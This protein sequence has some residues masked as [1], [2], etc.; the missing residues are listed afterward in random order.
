MQADI[1]PTDIVGWDIGGAHLKAS[2]LS[3]EGQVMAVYQEPCPLWQGLEKLEYALTNILARVPH[4]L[5]LHVITMSGELVDLFSNRAEGVAKIIDLTQQVL[6]QQTLL[7]YAG[8]LGFISAQQ[9][10]PEYIDKIASANWLASATYAARQQEQ[11]LLVDIGST[12]TD[13]LLFHNKQLDV[14]G[15]TDFQRLS[16]GELVYTGIVRTAVMAVTQSV[17]FAGKEVGVM[18]EYFA[19]MADVY[20]LTNELDER[21]DQSDTADGHAKTVQA[22]T[23]RLARMVGC[24]V[25]DFPAAQWLQLAYAIREQQLCRIQSACEQQL[26]R[27]DHTINKRIIGA[28]VG[29]FLAREIASRLGIEYRDFNTLFLTTAQKTA[30]QIADC[31]PAVAVAYLAIEGACKSNIC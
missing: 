13:I 26:L 20:R 14:L 17:Y 16:S 11:G 10:T 7:V 5:T 24:D 28:G 27:T 1:A 12:T 25:E 31:A 15:Y 29:R 9:V 3:A 30:M 22:S 4:Q 21:H 19:T 8:Q 18:S 2:W 23:R 6:K